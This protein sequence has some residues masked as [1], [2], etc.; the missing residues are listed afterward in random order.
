MTET[1][2]QNRRSRDNRVN[3]AA[4]WLLPSLGSF[5]ILLVLYLLIGSSWRFLV[6]SDTGW[7][8]RTGEIILQTRSVVRR[9]PFSHTMYGR[10]WFAWEWLSEVIMALLHRWRGLAGVVAGAI[11]VLLAA[12]TLLYR[13]MIRRGSDAVIAFVLTIFAS[14][15]CIVQWLAR[16][17]LV[18]I[19]LMIVWLGMVEDFRR[20]RS[21]VIWFIPLLIVLWANLHGAFA[22]TF[23]LLGIYGVGEWIESGIRGDWWSPAVRT[24]TGTYLAVGLT[25]AVAAMATPFGPK[26]FLHLFDYLTDSRLLSTIVEFQSPNFHLINGKL[27]EVLLLFGF[28][29]AANAVRQ[30]KVIE[31]GLVLLWGHMTLQ[32]ER[33]VTLAAVIICPLIAQQL[34]LLA[35]EFL[36]HRTGDDKPA[37]RAL[38]AIRQWYRGVM[39]ID[40]QLTG[41][42]LYLAILFFVLWAPS[43]SLAGKLLSPR[44][45]PERF[46]VEAADF[47]ERSNLQGRMFAYDQFGGYLIYRL[48]PR[49]RVFVDGR[50]DFYRQGNVLADTDIISQAG[51][52]WPEKLDQYEIQWMLLKRDEPLARIARLSGY[53][54]V[55][56]EDKFNLILSRK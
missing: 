9:D 19:A 47:I 24:V 11:L 50:S 52:Q 3:T 13:Q 27:I 17:H 14:L 26:L 40:A 8:I 34:T 44:F 1:R 41:A 15:C 16:P 56:Y 22:V 4:R 38:G 5:C 36:D 12:Y 23:V 2:P 54:N 29:A 30:G 25:S 20:R 31:A 46:P 21:R 39:S 37:A 33:H 7:H 45:A 35:A 53:W 32:S 28:I 42:A 48:Y 43:G 51:P 6:D 55:I 49:I 10:E 18:S